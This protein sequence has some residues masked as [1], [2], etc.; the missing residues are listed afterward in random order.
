MKYDEEKLKEYPEIMNK[1]QL[2]I[3]CHISKRTALFL[4]QFNLIPNTCTGKKTR[5]YKIRKQDIIAFM[6]DR[7][8]NPQRYIAPEGWYRYG[9]SSV[10]PYKIRIRPSVAFDAEKTRH[11]YEYALTA[12]PDVLDVQ[13]VVEF[14][15]YNRRTVGAWV[16]AGKLKA[17]EL[18]NKYV[19]PKCYLIDWLSSVEYDNIIRQSSKHVNI[20]WTISKW[21]D[22]IANEE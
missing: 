17:L 11:F 9:D 20:L 1:E 5:C 6:N 12:Y 19:I 21:N 13:D 2:R 14:T 3:A 10:K 8:V 7:E 16:R 22:G 18:P 15:G 4:L